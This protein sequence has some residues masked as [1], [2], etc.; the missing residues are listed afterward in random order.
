VPADA[1]KPEAFV[2]R[3]LISAA[4]AAAVALSA[5]LADASG[6]RA[7]LELRQ[8]AVGVILVNARGFTVYAF[9]RDSRD[10]DACRAILRCLNVW[11]P[12]LTTGKP[13][14]GPGL[15]AAMIGTITLRSGEKQVTYGG[16]PLYTYIA[17]VNPGQTTYVNRLQFGGRWPAINSAGRTVK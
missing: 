6:V 4:A 1:A 3:V 12:V 13:L 5:A 15:R 14:A 8:T 7:K 17:D 10:E 2:K 9:T 16:H 11:P